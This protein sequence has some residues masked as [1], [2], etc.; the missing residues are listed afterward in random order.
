MN[1]CRVT[2]IMKTRFTDA[3]GREK[4]GLSLLSHTMVL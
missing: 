3:V 4:G 2:D 1:L